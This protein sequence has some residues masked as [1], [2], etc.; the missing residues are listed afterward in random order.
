L[1][2]PADGLAG[3]LSEQVGMLVAAIDLADLALD[4]REFDPAGHHARADVFQSAVH[5]QRPQG[6]RNPS[7][8]KARHSGTRPTP[9][10][11][12]PSDGRV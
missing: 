8:V 12:S 3:P 11:P 5:I 10:R 9:A 6:R 2:D 1:P 7:P 4:R